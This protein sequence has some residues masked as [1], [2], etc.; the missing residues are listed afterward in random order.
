[1][2]KKLKIGLLA[3]LLVSFFLTSC[4]S[5]LPVEQG[6]VVVGLNGTPTNIDPRYATDAYSHQVIELCYN[7]LMKKDIKGRPV[8]DLAKEV[9]AISPTTY[10]VRL[11][12]GIT[13]HDGSELTARDVKYTYEFLKDPKN[14][15]PHSGTFGKIKE[16][17]TLNDYS[18][19]IELKE[20]FA[21]FP[22]ALTVPIVKNGTPKEALK[23]GE[24]GT[25]PFKMIKYLPDEE[26]E[27]VP[28]SNYFEGSPK[29][30]KLKVKI[31]MDDNVR[32]LQLKKGEINFVINGVTP[33]LVE[34]LKKEKK[35]EVIE[36]PGSNFS[37]LGF[38]LKDPVLRNKKVREAI[39]HGINRQQIIDSILKGLAIPGET[40]ISPLY[41]AHEP[42]VR[43]YEY[44][45][46]LS[47][48]LLDEAGYPDPDGAGPKPRFTL[49]YK[50]S[51]NDLRRRIAQVIQEQLR[52]IGIELKIV[53]Y[54]WGTFFDDIKKGNFQLYS[55]TWVGVT[56]PDI[57]Y[58]AFHS[59]STPPMGANRN[60]YA[61]PRLDRL[62]ELG[63]KTLSIDER[64]KIYSQVQKIISEDL[65]IYGLWFNVNV[66]VKDKRIR[67]FTLFPDES[68]RPLKN[69]WIEE[70]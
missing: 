13:F 4:S 17:R 11:K 23:D 52:E 40:L 65:P 64:K 29:I 25:G 8:P 49:T 5:K 6:V 28:Y 67:G 38:N 59:K 44:D 7:G 70:R 53:S 31:V 2:G 15:T 62:V 58:Y 24:N 61:N 69:V 36:S 18:L 63:R 54:E 3:V 48:K 1:M 45:P 33:D 27:F 32:F 39:A 50:T 68:F 56:D 43:K 41:W 9:V 51:Q 16:I 22:T 21:P 47:R 46:E 12:K 66:L 30:K 14:G 34:E 26:L 19:E 60:G 37:Y 57:Y 35:L 20:P 42:N 10:L 55:L